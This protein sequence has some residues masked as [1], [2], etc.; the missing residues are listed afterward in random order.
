MAT[1]PL[2][3]CSALHDAAERMGPNSDVVPLCL[4][5]PGRQWLGHFSPRE[6]RVSRIS[7]WRYVPPFVRN[8]HYGVG[9]RSRIRGF[10]HDDGLP[11]HLAAVSPGLANNLFASACDSRRP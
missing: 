11:Q 5:C 8:N 6:K 2:E 9:K 3:K 7:V 1:T 4:T 10:A